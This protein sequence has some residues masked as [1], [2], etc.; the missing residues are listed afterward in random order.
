M[1][2]PASAATLT[3]TSGAPYVPLVYTITSGEKA[4]SQAIVV[5]DEIYFTT[6]GGDVNAGTYGTT[7][8]ATGHAYK[9]DI[10]TNTGSSVVITGGA[11]SLVAS[12]TAIYASSRDGAQRLTTD[13]T[14]TTGEAVNNNPDPKVT[15]RIW[16]RSN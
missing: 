7:S 9:V 16:L 6:D 4:S 10:N 12:G 2:A 13:A 15:K 1:A 14:G 11:G 3:E 5:G 8:T